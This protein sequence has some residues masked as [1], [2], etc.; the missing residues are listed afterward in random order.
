MRISKKQ[1]SFC[2]TNEGNDFNCLYL[3]ILFL[4]D[5]N[6][7]VFVV[8]WLTKL[9]ISFDFST[10]HLLSKI[11]MYKYF[12]YKKSCHTINKIYHICTLLVCDIRAGNHFYSVLARASLYPVVT[13]I[14][15]W[16][17]NIVRTIC[18]D[19]G[20][21]KFRKSFNNSFE[22]VF[23]FYLSRVSVPLF[24]FYTDL[25]KFLIKLLFIEKKSLYFFIV[26]I[27]E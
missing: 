5:V 26:L 20:K 3:A 19:F 21:K 14:E 4:V 8:V 24:G 27:F 23:L 2:S 15:F 9:H 22:L 25:G 13:S 7:M 12:L 17:S 10:R 11:S 6:K 1:T 18:I 16:I